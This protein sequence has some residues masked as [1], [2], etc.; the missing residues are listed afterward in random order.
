MKGK[1]GFTLLE[2][3]VALAILSI[4]LL[5]MIELIAWA[6]RSAST[7]QEHT[8]AVFL[9][10]QKMEELL[11]DPSLKEGALEGEFNGGYRWSVQVV[12]KGLREI[13][14]PQEGRWTRLMELRVKVA[15]PSRG[16]ERSLQ[17]TSLKAVGS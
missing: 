14:S 16:R 6:L 8:Q 12:E 1:Q 13:R 7:S 3:M 15:W 5:V 17:L 2:V 11:L 9:A 10:R 4:G